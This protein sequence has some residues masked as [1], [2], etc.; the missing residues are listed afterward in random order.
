MVLSIKKQRE[1]LCSMQFAR[2]CKNFLADKQSK[3]A[4]QTNPLFQREDV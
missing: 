4:D 2:T 3:N 1:E